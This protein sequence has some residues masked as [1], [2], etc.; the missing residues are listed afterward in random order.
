MERAGRVTAAFRLFAGRSPYCPIVESAA[1]P[2]GPQAFV[3]APLMAPGRRRGSTDVRAAYRVCATSR[4]GDPAPAAAADRERL[5][6]SSSRAAAVC[7]GPPCGERPRRREPSGEGTAETVEPGP[8]R[9]SVAMR[10]AG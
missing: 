1:V 9:L 8:W 7:G 2:N 5:P 10:Q 3:V 4:E 6:T